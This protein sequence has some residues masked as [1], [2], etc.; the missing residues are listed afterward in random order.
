MARQDAGFKHLVAEVVS[1][2]GECSAGHKVGDR[3]LLGCWDTG[4]LCGFFYHDIFPSLSVLQFGGRYPW[5]EEE[6]VLECPDRQVAVTL[7]VR[8]QD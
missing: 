6:V 5:S 7:K 1:M 4:G 3:I 8:R 2:K